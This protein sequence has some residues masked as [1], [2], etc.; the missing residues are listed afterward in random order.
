[1]LTDGICAEDVDDLVATRQ[2]E[3]L[4]GSTDASE[5]SKVGEQDPSLLLQHFMLTRQ[6]ET[7][8]RL[9]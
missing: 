7:D 8:A 5:K 4:Q 9:G 6:S 1:M 2:R 3:I